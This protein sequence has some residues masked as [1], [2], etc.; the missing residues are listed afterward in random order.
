MLISRQISSI[1]L[2]FTVAAIAGIAV[3]AVKA[4]N[5]PTSSP[6]GELQRLPDCDKCT[7][8]FHGNNLFRRDGD[9]LEEVLPAGSGAR[10]TVPKDVWKLSDD[11][12]AGVGDHLV[13]KMADSHMFYVDG[14]HGERELFSSHIVSGMTISGDGKVVFGQAESGK[15]DGDGRCLWK[16]KFMRWSQDSGIKWLG[17]VQDMVFVQDVTTDGGKAFWVSNEGVTHVWSTESGLQLLPQRFDRNRTK[18]DSAGNSI[19]GIYQ[20]N[21][22]M[23]SK[24]T[25][26]V[27]LA[28]LPE[29]LIA[30]GD[31]TKY[32]VEWA[33]ADDT[34]A[35]LRGDAVQEVNQNKFWV[36]RFL[37][38][39]KVAGIIE[40]PA[41]S[42]SDYD[43]MS[44]N[45]GLMDQAAQAGASLGV[46]LGA[47]SNTVPGY[48]AAYPV[49]TVDAGGPAARASIKPGDFIVTLNGQQFSDANSLAAF[50]QSQ[51]AGNTLEVGVVRQNQPIKTVAV[52]D[53]RF[54]LN[55]GSYLAPEMQDFSVSRDGSKVLAVMRDYQG[56]ETHTRSYLAGT[57]D[58]LANLEYGRKIFTAKVNAAHQSEVA[59]KA[60]ADKKAAEQEAE[61]QATVDK[62]AA[63]GRPA[64]IYAYSM[65]MEDAGRF[66]VTSKLYSILID[67][68]PDDAYTAKAIDHQEKLRDEAR[69]QA[70][71]EKQAQE[72]AAAQQQQ[73]QQNAAANQQASASCKSQCQSAYS[74]CV[75]QVQSQNTSNVSGFLTGLLTHDASQ[76][77]TSLANGVNASSE[78]D[79]ANAQN[80]CNA[81][82][83]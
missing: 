71:A 43:K 40:I 67:K 69:A 77:M 33:N 22:V 81:S 60:D 82:C 2:L 70:A 38:W 1:A 49:L 83:Q 72:Q 8:E 79:C 7:Y 44:A 50:I 18:F 55:L 46:K 45:P 9:T 26:G 73:Q 75:E 76:T 57:H 19:V 37:L 63:T 66:D 61:I 30:D 12:R 65:T 64:Q 6:G 36:A 14:E 17:D 58:L 23:W 25:G 31:K 27:T 34:T 42:K 54:I 16:S 11:G 4:Q 10:I 52:L 62:L 78:T 53:S 35:I 47:V 48:A 80:T 13:G 51:S 20:N 15:C 21:L 41:L 24:A 59:A 32:E 5:A 29:H 3:P 74:I 28:T 68:F 56:S 39:S